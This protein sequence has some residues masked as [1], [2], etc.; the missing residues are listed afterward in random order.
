VK[1]YVNR[2]AP[3]SSLFFR[4]RLEINTAISISSLSCMA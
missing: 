1:F 4:V 2:L 3:G